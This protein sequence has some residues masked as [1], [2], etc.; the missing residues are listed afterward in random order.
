MI[1]NLNEGFGLVELLIVIAIIGI[2]LGIII[3]STSN[4]EQRGRDTAIENAVRQLRIQAEIAYENNSSYLNW[5]N[6]SDP[7]IGAELQI[8]LDEID[9]QFG[10]TS[11]GYVTFIRQ[12]ESQDFCISAPLRSESGRYF[13][14]DATGEFV[15]TTA[16][17]PASGLS[18]CP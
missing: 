15:R 13:C 2:L 7:T 1:K 6:L 14:A 8:L 9:A 18:R 17:C 12:D 11:P 10:D 3:A 4:S 16:H 5:A